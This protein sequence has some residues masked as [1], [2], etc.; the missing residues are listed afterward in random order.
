MNNNEKRL[1]SIES[2]KHI[3]KCWKA[4][5]TIAGDSDEVIFTLMDYIEVLEATNKA[6]RFV[7][8]EMSYELTLK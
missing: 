8:N 2:A 5:K 6:L 3:A 1:Y 7:N 4:G